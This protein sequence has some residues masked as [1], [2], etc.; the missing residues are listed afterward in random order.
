MKFGWT[1]ILLLHHKTGEKRLLPTFITKLKMNVKGAFVG[2]IIQ[3][4]VYQNQKSDWY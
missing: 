1:D 2:V 4:F 3:A